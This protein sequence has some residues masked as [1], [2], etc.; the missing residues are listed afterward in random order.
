[1]I[2]N[3]LKKIAI[4]TLLASAMATSVNAAAD[5]EII[6]T[7]TVTDSMVVGFVDVSAEAAA[8]GRF[9]GADVA[10]GAALP[11]AAWTAVTKNIFVN[12]NSASGVK[13]KVDDSVVA[14]GVLSGPGADVA[15][16]YTLMGGAYT[17]DSGTFISLIGTTNAGSISVG[18]FVITPAATAGTQTVGTYT[19]TL[20]VTLQA[21]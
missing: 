20:N 11:G 6:I 10:L 15:V 18:D 5:G 7:G 2:K 19:T 21:N 4:T 17:V 16:A 1:M 8:A 3:V 14:A 9:V 12:T 13:M